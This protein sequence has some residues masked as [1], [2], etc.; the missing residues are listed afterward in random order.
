[1]L[2]A[3]GAIM[4]GDDDVKVRLEEKRWTSLKAAFADGRVQVLVDYERHNSGRSPVYN[5]YEHV[6]P[7]LLLVMFS[8]TLLI[9]KG[10]IAGTSAL[11]VAALVYVFAVRPWVAKRIQ[12]RVREAAVDNLHDWNVMWKLGGIAISLAANPRVGCVAPDGD[13][14]TFVRGYV[15]DPQPGDQVV[16]EQSNSLSPF[17]AQKPRAQAQ[18]APPKP[19]NAGK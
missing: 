18:K 11:L 19:A 12:H 9:F 15:P 5:P 16:A 13:W 3:R 7:M 1:M 4:A 6:V 2:F 17:D 8:L 14:K 10:V